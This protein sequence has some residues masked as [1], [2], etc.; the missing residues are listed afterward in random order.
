M[1]ESLVVETLISS[2]T[3][4]PPTS[5]NK[6]TQVIIAYIFGPSTT[7]H[8]SSLLWSSLY[9]CGA[10]SYKIREWDTANMVAYSILDSPVASVPVTNTVNMAG[11]WSID[12]QI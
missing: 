9:S 7:D 6:L 2:H 4:S 5:G 12:R 1:A 3:I 8:A 11:S 10:D